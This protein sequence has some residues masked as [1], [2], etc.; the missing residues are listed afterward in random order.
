MIPP[1]VKS[2]HIKSFCTAQTFTLT[3]RVGWTPHRV[4]GD[5]SWCSSHRWR[6]GL[7][8]CKCDTC[9]RQFGIFFLN[10]YFW[11]ISSQADSWGQR[12]IPLQLVCRHVLPVK[13]V[14]WVAG[15][16]WNL[17]QAL[18]SAH[19]LFN[20]ILIVHYFII[21]RQEA[22]KSQCNGVWVTEKN[23]HAGV[24]KHLSL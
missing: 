1:V 7:L 3:Y 6:C 20:G 19:S 16:T 23:V 4:R 8:C 22:N 18:T 10:S 24:L 9:K 2:F 11:Q 15:V 12:Y 14:H 17:V 13:I 5:T 21:W